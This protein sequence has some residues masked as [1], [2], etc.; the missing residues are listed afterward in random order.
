MLSSLQCAMA[1]PCN[2]HPAPSLKLPASEDFHMTSRFPGPWRIAEFPNGFA[3]YDATG[4]HLG[5]FY[6]RTDPNIAGRGDFL[7]IEDARQ[8]AIDFAMLPELLNLISGRSEVAA[9][10]EDDKLAKLKTNCAPRGAPETSRLIRL[11]GR[12]SQQML[13]RPSDPRSIPTKFLIP[14][15]VATFPVG[16]LFLGDSDPPVNVAVVPQVTTNRLSAEFSPQKASLSKAMDIK[17]DSRIEEVQTS[18]FQPT[19][20]LDIK[21]MEI[22]IEAGPPDTLPQK[23]ALS[24]TPN[25]DASACFPSASAVLRNY[26]ESRPSWILRAPGHEGT[27]CWYPTKRTAPDTRKEK[28]SPNNGRT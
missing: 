19:M 15:V 28:D 13:R 14:I 20:P 27:R 12:R 4:R 9:S 17:I 6:G 24:I 8:I 1:V 11:D 2:S 7:M 23:E 21:P 5:F 25:Q 10:T 18:P 3:V 22:G 16:C 26:P